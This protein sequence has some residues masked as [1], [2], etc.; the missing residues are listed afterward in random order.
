MEEQEVAAR[1]VSDIE[2]NMTW[3]QL[4]GVAVTVT[5]AVIGI[6]LAMR[7][8]AV[9][10]EARALYWKASALSDAA[11]NA[12]GARAALAAAIK[13]QGSRKKLKTNRVRG[14]I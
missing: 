4:G 2:A 13:A 11:K 5:L 9:L 10:S 6:V 7:A 14:V 12:G 8:Y 3:L 1:L